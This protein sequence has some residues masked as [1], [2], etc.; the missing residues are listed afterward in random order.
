MSISKDIGI[1]YI[2]E[3][4]MTLIPG[5]VQFSRPVQRTMASNGIL[6]RFSEKVN[7]RIAEQTQSLQF[8]H[9]FG[10]WQ[11]N[12]KYASKVVN[13]DGTPRSIASYSEYCCARKNTL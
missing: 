11:N 12:P 13:P 5:G 3:K 8:M 4:A 6:H 2:N 9:W 1:Y 7:M 10:D